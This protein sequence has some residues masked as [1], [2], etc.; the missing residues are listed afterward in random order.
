MIFKASQ[1]HFY[2]NIVNNDLEG[3][4]SFRWC[5]KSFARP[6][7]ATFA[8]RKQ[9]TVTSMRA[10][11]DH[12]RRSSRSRREHVLSKNRNGLP[13]PETTPICVLSR[14]SQLW[15]AD[16]GDR[17]GRP[18]WTAMRSRSIGHTSRSLHPPVGSISKFLRRSILLFVLACNSHLGD[19]QDTPP[20]TTRQARVRQRVRRQALFALPRFLL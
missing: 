6:R 11:H 7:K 18:W 14:Q 12:K 2:L 17:E 10:C 13:T 8:F 3:E 15:L 20:T 19:N 16:K 9:F 4:A 1:P 5:S